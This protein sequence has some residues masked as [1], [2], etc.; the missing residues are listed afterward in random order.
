MILLDSVG[1][2]VSGESQPLLSGQHGGE[3]TW[4]YCSNK[5]NEVTSTNCFNTR[6]SLLSPRSF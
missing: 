5:S 3:G 1:F 2:R 6:V 4:D